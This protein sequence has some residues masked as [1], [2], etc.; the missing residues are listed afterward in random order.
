[1]D[2]ILDC[3]KMY[4]VSEIHT[5]LI[6]TLPLPEYYGRN[7]DA[8]WDVL[9]TFKGPARI[10]LENYNQTPKSTKP[11][12]DTMIKMIKRLSEKRENI[13]LEIK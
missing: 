2:F 13:N 12:I 6:K 5:Q 3:S 10:I 11:Y 1:M 7:L 9:S 4:S 8:L